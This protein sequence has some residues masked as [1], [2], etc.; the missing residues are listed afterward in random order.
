MLGTRK[1]DRWLTIGSRSLR[2]EGLGFIAL[3]PRV[4]HSVPGWLTTADARLLY[5]FAH[6]GPGEGAIV[7]IGSAWG[8][9]TVA[10]ASGSKRA[11]REPVYAIDPHTGDDWWLRGIAGAPGALGTRDEAT[12]S[13]PGYSSL[14]SFRETLR[15]YDVEDHVVTVVST[16][17]DAAEQ[18]ETGPIRLLFVDGLHTYEGVRDDIRNWVPRVVHGGIVVFDD[19]YNPLPGVGAKQAID[20][21]LTTGLVEPVLCHTTDFHVWTRRR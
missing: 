1:L 16:S 10:L 4:H 12:A 18:L 5:A 8:R 21:L 3:W 6:H 9:S 7:E 17:N 14:D 19:Y 13:C 2:E 20:E 11:G 15:R